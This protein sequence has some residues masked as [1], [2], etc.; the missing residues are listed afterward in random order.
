VV[1]YNRNRDRAEAVAAEVVERGGEAML[2][3]CDI[4]DAGSIQAAVTRVTERWDGVDVLVQAALRPEGAT[5]GVAFEEQSVADWDDSLHANLWGTM[6]V[7]RAVVPSMRARGWGRIV[8]I[9]ANA[10]AEGVAGRESYAAGKAG[11][12]GLARSLTTS[13][14]SADILVNGVVLSLVLTEKTRQAVPAPVIEQYEQATPT[15]RL[16]Q[17]DDIADAI[18]FLASRANHNICGAFLPVTGGR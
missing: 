7:I 14:G 2:T 5:W 3:P 6:A 8:L 17:P 10:L 11:L 13:L 15:G 16:S 1:A 9:A 12:H 4:A 18:V